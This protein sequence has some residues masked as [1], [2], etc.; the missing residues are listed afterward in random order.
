MDRVEKF[1]SSPEIRTLNAHTRHYVIHSYYIMDGALTV[2]TSCMIRM[3]DINDGGMYLI[4]KHEIDSFGKLDSRSYTNCRGFLYIPVQ[5]VP[6]LHILK[7]TIV[8]DIVH[9]HE[10]EKCA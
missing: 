1:V 9:E 3:A 5:H 2:C 8:N 7:N 10:H 6:T 4:R